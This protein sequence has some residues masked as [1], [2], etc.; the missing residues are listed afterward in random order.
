MVNNTQIALKYFEVSNQSNFD[1][2]EKLLHENATYSSQNTGLYLWIQD[3]LDMQKS[4]HG[5]FESLEWKIIDSH[6]EKPGIIKVDFEFIWVKSWEEL[7]F[8][9]VEYIIV[10]NCKIQHIEIKNK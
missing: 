4:F 7:R 10:A 3:I 5:S 9:G 8:Q 2:I 1:E 6:E